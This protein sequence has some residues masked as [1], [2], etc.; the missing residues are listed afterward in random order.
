MTNSGRTSSAGPPVTIGQRPSSR[1]LLSEFQHARWSPAAA[2]RSRYFCN[3]Q[4]GRCRISRGWS[5]PWALFSFTDPAPDRQRCGCPACNVR[6]LAKCRAGWFRCPARCCRPP[7]RRAA[8]PSAP[9]PHQLTAG[10]GPSMCRKTK[11]QKLAFEAS[12]VG[13]PIRRVMQYRLAA[14]KDGL[15][16]DLAVMPAQAEIQILFSLAPAIRAQGTGFPP[17]RK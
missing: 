17:W 4:N 6:H 3:L 5:G 1:P 2:D 14:G 9:R 13:L 7:C 10:G 16:G 11:Q 12:C 15:F 8:A